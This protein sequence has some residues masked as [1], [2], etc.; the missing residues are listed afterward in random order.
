MEFI[1]QKDAKLTDAH[2]RIVHKVSRQAGAK[3]RQARGNQVRINHGQVPEFLL[4]KVQ[5]SLTPSSTLPPYALG[6]PTELTILFHPGLAAT[7]R[8]RAAEAEH[9][10]DP[11]RWTKLCRLAEDSVL[12]KLP[13]LYG[14]ST[15]LDRSIDCVAARI[16]DGLKLNTAE[17]KSEA[18]IASIYG[19]AIHSLSN[20]FSLSEVD[21]CSWYATWLLTFF[22]ASEFCPL[23]FACY[24]V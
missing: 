24:F 6:I 2:R 19:Q 12:Q 13:S 22:E 7:L 14:H 9:E 21:W 15:C 4:H 18:H 17:H 20:A 11:R 5:I 10:F 3:T 8:Y 1:N 16:H 23:S